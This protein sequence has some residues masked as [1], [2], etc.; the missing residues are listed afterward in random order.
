MFQDNPNPTNPYDTEAEYVPY[1]Q[2]VQRESPV[3]GTSVPYNDT[4]PVVQTPQAL[5]TLPPQKSPQRH[6]GKSIVAV[7]ALSLILL[8]VL[9]IGLFA[10]WEFAHGG[11]STTSTG[12]N[13]ATSSTSS[14][15]N[16]T[17]NLTT[18]QGVQEA[19]INNIKPAVVELVVTTQQGEQIGSGVIVDSKGDIITNNHV[20]DG[21][22]SITV[23][24]SNGKKEIGQLAGTAAQ[25]DLAVVR[26]QPFN[27][28]TVAPIG[29]SSQLTVGQ[30]VLAV[31]NPLGITQTATRGIVSALNRNIAE[32][33]TVNITG[34][35]Q[36]DAPINPGNSGG[37]LINLRGELIG[38]PTLAAINTES[39]TSANGIGFAIPSNV[40][41]T[42]LAQ[43]LQQANNSGS[44][45]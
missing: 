2:Y 44:N 45:V 37:A 3:S 8:A 5:Q 16:Q 15:S 21:G 12:S 9:A 22:N 35:I 7:S 31:G 1:T 36:T 20:V 26:I 17:I 27:H 34:A 4:D 32:S 33:S 11:T 10:G 40:V 13:Q 29:N 41:K 25:T 6:T 30:E 42:T 18:L 14:S 43:I 39:N 38:I 24:L 19:A 23:V 28:M